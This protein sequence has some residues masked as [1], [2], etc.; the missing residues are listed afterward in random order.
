MSTIIPNSQLGPA[1]A[2]VQ[3][4]QEH[5]ELPRGSW[6]ID[7]EVP[8]LHG[9]LHGADLSGLAAY[10]ALLGGDVCESH[11]Y[12]VRGDRVRSHR[13]HTTWRDIELTIAVVVPAPAL[14]TA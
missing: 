14:V 9:H 10:R 5:P 7:Q 6:S 8:T 11:D 2:L 13:L 4:L 1:M 3:L 12:T